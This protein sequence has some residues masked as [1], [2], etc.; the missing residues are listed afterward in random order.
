MTAA[1]GAGALAL[2]A[3]RLRRDAEAHAER[4][5]AAARAEAATTLAL[6]R[7]QAATTIAGASAAA[8]A[9]AGPLTHSTLRQAH[10]T[11]RAAVLAAQREARDELRAHVR[12]AVAGL[13]GQPDWDQLGERI[14]RLAAQAAG[15]DARLSRDPGGGFVA[16]APGVV[17]D[18]SLRRLAD[19]AVDELGAAAGELWAP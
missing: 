13:P 1:A 7:E 18:C 11:A 4:I 16:T 19:L 6:A 8:A 15:P 5:R 12:A 10:A 17:V 3:G 2:V 9:A 14:A